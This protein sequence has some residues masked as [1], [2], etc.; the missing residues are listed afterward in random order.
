M[1]AVTFSDE[2]TTAFDFKTYVDKESVTN[3]IA[4]IGRTQGSTDVA[5]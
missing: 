2:P 3:A 5:S 1:A 4:N